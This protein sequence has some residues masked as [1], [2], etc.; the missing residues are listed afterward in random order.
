M[1]EIE[2]LLTSQELAVGFFARFLSAAYRL[3]YG[4]EFDKEESLE[5]LY[6][7]ET[8]IEGLLDAVRNKTWHR[9]IHQLNTLPSMEAVRLQSLRMAFSLQKPFNATLSHLPE[10]DMVDWGYLREGTSVKAKW[11]S[12]TNINKVNIILKATLQRCKCKKTPCDPTKKRCA[13]RRTNPPS[14]CSTLCSC[15]SACLNQHPSNTSG[16]EDDV[17]VA[18]VE[19]DDDVEEEY[20]DSEDDTA[21]DS[22][23]GY[24]DDDEE[25]LPSVDD[26]VSDG[27]IFDNLQRGFSDF[28]EDDHDDDYKYL[29]L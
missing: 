3:K 14:S 7:H 12:Q 18:A 9:T 28:N 20:S 27:N 22:D 29:M 15:S 23:F 6:E 4:T 11:D 16:N 5:S 8:G 19:D 1:S 13:C 2:D 26:G 25:L 24:E 10:H 21:N 17:V